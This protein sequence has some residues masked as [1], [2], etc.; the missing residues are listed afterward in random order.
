MKSVLIVVQNQK[1]DIKMLH[2]N[3]CSEN[4]EWELRSSNDEYL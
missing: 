3:L 1:K 2:L 4:T